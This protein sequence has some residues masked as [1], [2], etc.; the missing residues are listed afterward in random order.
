MKGPE[1]MLSERLR[2]LEPGPGYFRIFLRFPFL[3]GVVL[4]LFVFLFQ[5][6]FNNDYHF[7]VIDWIHK[8]GTIPIATQLSQAYHPP[9]YYVL[10]QLFYGGDFSMPGLKVLQLFSLLTSLLTFVVFT[11]MINRFI[12]SERVRR[13]ATLLAACLP[14]LIMFGNFVSNDSLANLIGAL[15]FLQAYLYVEKPNPARKVGLAVIL[16]LG[17]LTKGTFLAFIPV[18]LGLVIVVEWRS[19]KR[20][21]A[22]VLSALLVAALGLGIGAYKY[23]E[24]YRHFGDPFIHNADPLVQKATK[25]NWAAAQKHTFTGLGSV[26][27]W[28]IPKLMLHPTLGDETR[29]SYFLMMYG[30]FWYQYLYESNL[31]GNKTG[32]RYLGSLI[33]LLALVPTL[34]MFLGAYDAGAKLRAVI[35]RRELETRTIQ[36]L[37]GVLAFLAAFGLVVYLGIRIDIWSCFQSR[38]FFPA[39][40]GVIV[41]FSSGLARIER[42]PRIAPTVHRLLNVLF[43][44]FALYFLTELAIILFS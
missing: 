24:S 36:E 14:Q 4:R 32:F 22:V 3:A 16:G 38:L 7:Q 12:E 20:W 26:F 30:T 21:T 8:N 31:M 25:W 34:V 37:F 43:V 13:S 2:R 33:Y 15:L 19:R 9:L 44:C 41:L 23:V 10:A 42:R 18:V 11:L 29:H 28:N 1:T 40:W 35:R 5:D 27:D 6:P 39:F 17:L